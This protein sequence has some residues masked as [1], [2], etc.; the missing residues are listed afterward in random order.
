M[1]EYLHLKN[2]IFSILNDLFISDI[3]FVFSLST[4]KNMA[5]NF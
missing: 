4:T 2:A 5:T 3:S 1:V